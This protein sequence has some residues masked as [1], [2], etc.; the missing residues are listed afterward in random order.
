MLKSGKADVEGS[1]DFLWGFLPID[2]EF[3]LCCNEV[4]AKNVLRY[5][6]NKA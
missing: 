5:L 3:K 6:I 4:Q 1:V 2:P